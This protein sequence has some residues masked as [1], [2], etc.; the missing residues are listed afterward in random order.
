MIIRYLIEAN[1]Q[2]ETLNALIK[3]YNNEY[4]LFYL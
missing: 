1:M 4:L 2:V 3:N